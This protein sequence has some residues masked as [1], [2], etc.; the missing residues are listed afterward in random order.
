MR[1]HQT[2]GIIILA[3]FLCIKLCAQSLSINS[4]I[5]DNHSHFSSRSFVSDFQIEKSNVISVNTKK[6]TDLSYLSIQRCCK[7]NQV[8]FGLKDE[9]I[10]TYTTKTTFLTSILKVNSNQT[11][12]HKATKLIN[13]KLENKT[14]VPNVLLPFNAGIRRVVNAKCH[15]TST[16]YIKARASGGVKPY[17][18]LWSNG[19]TTDEITNLPIGVYTLTISDASGNVITE[20]ATVHEPNPIEVDVIS[21]APTCGSAND[22][23]AIFN[24]KGGTPFPYKKS[25]FTTLWSNTQSNG[26]MFDLSTNTKITLTNLSIHLPG[27]HLQTISIY[28][29]AGSMMGSEFDSSQWQLI[30]STPTFGAGIDEETPISFAIPPTLVPGNYSLYIYNHDGVI[31]GITSTVIGNTLNYDHILSVFEGISRDSN[32]N[33][34]QSG[35]SGMMNMSGKITYIVNSDHGFSYNNNMADGLWFQKQFSSGQNEIFVSDALG[36]SSSK[37]FVIPQADSIKVSTTLIRSP[38][39]FNTNDGE[40]NIQASA[41]NNEYHSMTAIPF[42]NPANGSM[43]HFTSTDDLL[44]KGIDLF[45]NQNG[46]V[47]VYIM[48]GDYVGNENNTSSWTSLGNY[49][50]I[51]TSNSL[52]SQL[53]LTNPYLCT[54]G[55]WSLYLYSAYDIFNQLDSSSFF[56]NHFL[57]YHHSSS[58]VGNL[59]A[60]FTTDKSN[61][62]WTGNIIYGDPSSNLQYH[63]SNQS[64]GSHQTNLTGGNYQCTILQDNGC[65]QIENF[66][67]P[68]PPPIIANEITHSE[69][70]F[71]QNGSASLLLQGGTPPYY[72][73]WLNSGITGNQIHHLPEGPQPYFVSDAKGCTLYDTLNI[74][75]VISPPKGHGLLTIAPNPGAGY[76]H[77]TKEVHGMEDCLLTIFDFTGRL[78]H[79]TNTKISI[80]M[81]KGLDMSHY[82]DG[83]YFIIVRDE[84]QV[85]QAKANIAR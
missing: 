30:S 50:L 46:N 82:S 64:V 25:L 31:N 59:G 79:S 19:N 34:F 27:L 83:N 53:L 18:F 52:T 49:A 21:Y 75:R 7:K 11:K 24:P 70:D 6:S 40:I 37:T 32:T 17:Q 74:L 41:A 68:N 14:I 12:T 45:L 8:L 5:L 85:F 58:R 13:S 78:I 44:L 23:Q 3:H 62:Y 48:Q 73:Q 72:I 29:K 56:D 20:S 51:K 42:T 43:I 80:L 1:T 54:S 47:S 81:Q 77:I 63:W 4:K 10:T 65:I 9:S 76:I 71:E 55:N 67:I 69:I 33:P 39:C 84:D 26:F 16:G 61:S 60:F 38:R 57:T 22:G 35:I 66:S 28:L 15:G 36:C 2:Y